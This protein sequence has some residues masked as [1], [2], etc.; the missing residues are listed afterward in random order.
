MSRSVRLRRSRSLVVADPG[1]G[2]PEGEREV[3]GRVDGVGQHDCTV[4][5][6]RAQAGVSTNCPWICLEFQHSVLVPRGY[7]VVGKRRSRDLVVKLESFAART[8]RVEL[9]QGE[10]LELAGQRVLVWIIPAGMPRMWYSTPS[11]VSS[12]CSEW[13]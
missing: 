6:R 13:K 10:V 4:I 2:P 7:E 1:P 3:D 5:Q 8:F 11:L 12:F 9:E